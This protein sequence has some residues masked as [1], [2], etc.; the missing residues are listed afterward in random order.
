MDGPGGKFL[1]RPA[2]SCDDGRC[3]TGAET[4]DQFVDFAHDLAGANEF[5]ETRTALE[6]RCKLARRLTHFDIGFGRL[7]NGAQLGVVH[8]LRDEVLSSLFHGL[9]RKIDAGVRR[10]ENHGAIW[11]AC[12]EATK[13]IESR[14]LRHHDIGN[15][16]FRIVRLDKVLGFGTIRCKLYLVTPLLQDHLEYFANRRL[17]IDDEHLRLVH[18]GRFLP[19]GVVHLWNV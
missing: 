17:I 4:L 14:K 1:S 6:L 3:I 16:D 11:I 12:L 13:Q 18:V 5:A 9:D 7:E 10:D 2:L 15:Y 8:R 19:H